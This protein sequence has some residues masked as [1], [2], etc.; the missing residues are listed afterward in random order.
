MV[1]L[2]ATDFV[3]WGDGPELTLTGMLG[4]F[5]FVR[6]RIMQRRLRESKYNGKSA[7]TV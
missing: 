6:L 2:T 4:S 5:H 7:E 1:D 3:A